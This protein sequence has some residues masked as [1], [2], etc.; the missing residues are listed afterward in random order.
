MAFYLGA[1]FGW[2]TIS[3]TIRNTLFRKNRSKNSWIYSILILLS[4]GPFMSGIGGADGGAFDMVSFVNQILVGLVF[5]GIAIIYRFTGN[6]EVDKTDFEG[7]LS[8]T[9]KVFLVTL[10]VFIYTPMIFVSYLA[11]NIIKTNQNLFNVELLFDQ[12]P[13]ENQQE[14]VD[15]WIKHGL[16]K[17]S[18]E[19]CNEIVKE[20]NNTAPKQL[21]AENRLVKASCSNLNGVILNYLYEVTYKSLDFDETRPRVL[22]QWCENDNTRE[23]LNVLSGVKFMY[24]HTS[25]SNSGEILIKSN[26]CL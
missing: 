23:L 3:Y 24:K 26:D 18:I 15:D 19:E 7:P 4:T 14:I 2:Y 25:G 12:I 8:K 21:N 10:C 6:S 5:L 1:I 20:V 17:I 16:Y 11:F 13:P 22:K 9:S